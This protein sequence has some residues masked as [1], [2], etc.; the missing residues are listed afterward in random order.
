MGGLLHG[1]MKSAACGEPT[2]PHRCD[3]STPTFSPALDE[4]LILFLVNP[5]LFWVLF[6]IGVCIL[7]IRTL[8]LTV[9]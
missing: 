1:V 3:H 6:H 2:Q 8:L 4:S 9:I 5:V 7:A